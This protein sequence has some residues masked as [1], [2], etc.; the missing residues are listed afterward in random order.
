MVEDYISK[1]DRIISTSI[2]IICESGLSALTTKN[3][4]IKEN[5]SE[6]LLYKYYGS[7]DEVLKDVVDYYFKFDKGIR[8]TVSSKESSCID[9]IKTYV[10]SYAT[11]YDNYYALSVIMLQY[12]ELLHNP[13]TRDKVAEATLA[14]RSFIEALFRKAIEN[15]EIKGDIPAE[16]LAVLLTGMIY[17]LTLGRRYVFKRETFQSELN[18]YL[19]RV[20]KVLTID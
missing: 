20:I 19:E 17:Q 11:Y 5:M 10:D 4:A 13:V 7:V 8:A 15:K 16:Q 14:R 3:I 1:K 9:K 18:S 6:A 2:D 12:E